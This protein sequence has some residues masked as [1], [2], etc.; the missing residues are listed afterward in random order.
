MQ[1][2][3]F[4]WP[5]SNLVK[6]KAPGDGSCLFHSLAFAYNQSYRLDSI[7]GRVISSRKFVRELRDQLANLLAAPIDPLDP[8]GKKY[9]DIIARGSLPEISKSFPKYS[10]KSMQATLRSN[11]SID[12][13]Y[14]EFIADVI[15][16]DIYILSAERRDVYITGE[17]ELFQKNRPSIILL[18]SPGHYDLIGE[19]LSDGTIKTLFSPEDSVIRLIRERLIES[20]PN[21]IEEKVTGGR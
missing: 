9:Y 11:D 17:E 1:V 8:T 15:D 5:Q 18:Y 20:K 21:R 4:N 6:I 14:L 7:G 13:V 16:K 12:Y 10:L 3:M 2:E 19:R